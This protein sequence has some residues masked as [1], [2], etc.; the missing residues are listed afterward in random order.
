[1]PLTKTKS[2]QKQHRQTVPRIT[3]RYGKKTVH[4]IVDK[5][6]IFRLMQKLGNRLWGVSGLS[7]LL[8]GMGVCFAIRPDMLQWSTAFSDFGRDVRTAPYLAASLFF[9]AYGLWR[10]RNYLR[11]TL[12]RAR[13]ITGLVTLTVVGLYI[14]AL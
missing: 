9:G 7:I 3:V 6:M 11:R 14:A 4:F 2:K 10:W 13:P 8:L 12:K 5:V 1:M